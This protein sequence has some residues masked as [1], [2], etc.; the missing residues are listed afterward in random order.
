MQIGD[1]LVGWEASRRLMIVGT[2]RAKAVELSP[3]LNL[4]D[5]PMVHHFLIKP[6]KFSIFDFDFVPTCSILLF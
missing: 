2:F 4:R 3:N 6:T 1:L 5:C